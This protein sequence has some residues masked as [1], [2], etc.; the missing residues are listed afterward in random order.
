MAEHSPAACNVT[1]VPLGFSARPYTQP[2]DSL[3]NRAAAKVRQS[4]S[5]SN[6]GMMLSCAVHACQS[7]ACAALMALLQVLT[8]LMGNLPKYVRSGAT[9]PALAAFQKHLGASTT[10]FAFGL[11]DSNLHAA[12][13]NMHLSMYRLARKAWVHLFFELAEQAAAVAGAD[14]SEL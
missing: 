2:K 6:S 14:H 9:I 7:T 5:S 12:D 11:P 3:P 1:M 4:S 8:G 10:V 13:E